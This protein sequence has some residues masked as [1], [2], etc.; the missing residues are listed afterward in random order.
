MPGITSQSP[1]SRTAGAPP[2]ACAPNAK[3]GIAP[4]G[5]LVLFLHFS[6]CGV[7]IA[8]RCRACGFSSAGERMRV[9]RGMIGECL[10]IRCMA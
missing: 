6:L 1:K 7:N 3:D 9:L 5:L 4:L 10:G 2:A 8:L